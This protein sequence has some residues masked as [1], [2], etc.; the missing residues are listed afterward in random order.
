MSLIAGTLH[1]R[2]VHERVTREVM[3]RATAAATAIQIARGAVV[4]LK[5]FTAAGL[6]AAVRRALDR[7]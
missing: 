6:A 1:C 7:N 5:P 4:L 2:A 3:A